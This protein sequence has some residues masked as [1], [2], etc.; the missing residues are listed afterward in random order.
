MCLYK[1]HVN[2]LCNKF[3]QN[4]PYYCTPKRKYKNTF[5]LKQGKTVRKLI[6]EIFLYQEVEDKRCTTCRRAFRV[7]DWLAR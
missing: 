5:C 3:L 4:N 6:F 7:N 2:N 1:N